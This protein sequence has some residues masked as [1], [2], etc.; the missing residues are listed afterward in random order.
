MPFAAK[1][2]AVIQEKAAPTAVLYEAAEP[3]TFYDFGARVSKIHEIQKSY[4]DNIGVG[5]FSDSYF[6]TLSNKDKA[7]LLKILNSG[8]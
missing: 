4:P 3:K 1:E 6:N 7:G 8:F 2:S 5:C